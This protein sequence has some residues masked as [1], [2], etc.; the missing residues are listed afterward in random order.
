MEEGG[1]RDGGGL[2]ERVRRRGGGGREKGLF[3]EIIFCYV[4][5]KFFFELLSKDFRV[6]LDFTVFAVLF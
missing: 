6:C 3:E 1:R 5:L 2:G 4:F